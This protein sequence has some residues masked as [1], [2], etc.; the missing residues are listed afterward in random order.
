MSK[1]KKSQTPSAL[2]VV[3]P[4]A[5]SVAPAVNGNGG[6][7]SSPLP[8]LDMVAIEK[9]KK[10][11]EAAQAEVDKAAAVLKEERAK[12][13]ELLGPVHELNRMAAGKK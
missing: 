12:L 7:K 3:T 5:K 13:S 9:A 11:I 2:A 1:L 6:G 4:A 8:Q 10:K